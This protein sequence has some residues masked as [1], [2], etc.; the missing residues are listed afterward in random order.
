MLWNDSEGNGNLGIEC[1]EGEGTDCADGESK[2]LI[3]EGH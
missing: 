3:G 1:E 2:T